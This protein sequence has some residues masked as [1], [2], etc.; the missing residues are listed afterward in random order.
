MPLWPTLVKFMMHNGNKKRFPTG[1]SLH[2]LF[3]KCTSFI[4]YPPLRNVI[5]TICIYLFSITPIYFS[6]NKLAVPSHIIRWNAAEFCRVSLSHSCRHLPVVVT[7]ISYSEVVPCSGRTSNSFVCTCSLCFAV[8]RRSASCS[9][10]WDLVIKL[11]CCF[12]F[13]WKSLLFPSPFSVPKLWP[14][15]SKPI[16]IEAWL[17]RVIDGTL[18]KLGYCWHT[19]CFSSEAVIRHRVLKLS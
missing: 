8:T 14:I 11:R 9:S 12:C 2:I 6:C 15:Y 18:S 4:I 3:K 19:Y 10:G 13:D 17:S 7:D 16:I 1:R 5:K